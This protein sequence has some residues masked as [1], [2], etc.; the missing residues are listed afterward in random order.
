MDEDDLRAFEGVV[1][2]EVSRR[3]LTQGAGLEQLKLAISEE[4]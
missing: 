4:S 1:R 3:V 2:V